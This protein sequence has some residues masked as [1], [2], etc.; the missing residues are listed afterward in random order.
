[1]SGAAVVLLAAVILVA[2]TGWPRSDS[3]P[4]LFGGVPVPRSCPPGPIGAFAGSRGLTVWS[5]HEQTLRM[6]GEPVLACGQTSDEETYRLTWLHSFHDRTPLLVRVSRRGT[7]VVLRASRFA[8]NG[9]GADQVLTSISDVTRTVTPGEW[10]QLLDQ[11]DRF[12]FW[13][14]PAS[15]VP[16]GDDGSTWLVEGR[17]GDTYRSMAR[18]SPEDGSF[19]SVALALLQLGRF[20]DPEPRER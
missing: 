10:S 20:D 4:H 2:G 5:W 15:L 12:S 13:A 7:A 19:R 14:Q 6:M 8:R 3:L 16:R 9:Q 18:H 1:M 11:F 17:R